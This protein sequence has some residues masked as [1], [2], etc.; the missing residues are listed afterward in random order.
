[1]C[2]LCVLFTYFMR[3][4]YTMCTRCANL[5]VP[6]RTFCEWLPSMHKEYTKCTGAKWVRTVCTKRTQSAHGGREGS[7]SMHKAHAKCTWG[8][9]SLQ[10]VC[11]KTDMHVTY[12]FCR[13]GSRGI[14]TPPSGCSTQGQ[15]ALAHCRLIV[16]LVRHCLQRT[17]YLC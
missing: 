10:Q 15:D 5:C 2:V 4:F 11:T 14:R 16:G 17:A 1:M 12:P 7:H 6:T 8:V 9:R 3:T 13:S